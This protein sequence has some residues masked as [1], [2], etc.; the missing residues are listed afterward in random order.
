MNNKFAIKCLS[1][2]FSL[3]YPI[4]LYPEFEEKDNRPY[5]VFLMRIEDHTFALPFRTNMNHKYGYKFKT[6]LK[7]TNTGTGLDFTKAVIVDDSSLIGNNAMVDKNEY[8]ELSEK[9]Y[10]IRNKFIKYLRNY[11]KYVNG[12]LDEYQSKAYQYSTLKYYHKELKIK[13]SSN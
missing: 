10:F 11:E 12:E 1:N 7:E 6:S 5:V 3:K 9:H 4:S 2:N 13:A 8:I